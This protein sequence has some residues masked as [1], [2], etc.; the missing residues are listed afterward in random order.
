[1]SSM[2]DFR[3]SI[4]WPLCA[5]LIVGVI[6]FRYHEYVVNRHYIINVNTACDSSVE[7]CFISDCSPAEDLG[8]PN[9]PYKKIEIRNAD[10]PKCLEEHQCT[11]FLCGTIESCK[12]TY[13]SEESLDAGESCAETQ[14]TEPLT[15]A[16]TTEKVSL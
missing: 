7:K 2:F 9:G 15:A 14:N 11:N 12:A 6:G 13:C 10:A 4:L 16:S 1:M 8:C 3:F 5:L